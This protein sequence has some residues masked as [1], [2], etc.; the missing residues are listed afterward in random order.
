MQNQNKAQSLNFEILKKSL[1][2]RFRRIEVVIHFQ[3]V[4]EKSLFERRIFLILYYAA[5]VDIG[6]KVSGY[7]LNFCRT[8][9]ELKNLF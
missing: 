8:K 4:I 2:E 5:A 9:F 1:T 3:I 7:L 6:E